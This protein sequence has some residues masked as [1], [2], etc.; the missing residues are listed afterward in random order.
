MKIK[1]NKF[2]AEMIVV[3]EVPPVV[4][5]EEAISEVELYNDY[6]KVINSS[7]PGLQVVKL[8]SRMKKAV[9]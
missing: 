4:K 6:L 7:K 3:C 8:N 1:T 5:S 2:T 9:I